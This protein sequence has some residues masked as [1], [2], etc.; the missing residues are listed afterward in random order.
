MS[1]KKFD[2]QALLGVVEQEE[3]VARGE[4][5]FIQKRHRVRTVLAGVGGKLPVR[6]TLS[7]QV[8]GARIVAQAVVA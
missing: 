4:I 3:L 1:S 7:Y 2:K 8:E 6:D 5:P